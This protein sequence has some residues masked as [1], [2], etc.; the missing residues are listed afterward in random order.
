[1]ITAI[2]TGWLALLA[3]VAVIVSLL[4]KWYL[5]PKMAEW[6]AEREKNKAHKANEAKDGP[7]ILRYIIGRRSRK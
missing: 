7:G 2:A 1:M 5:G 4:L 6:K 3:P